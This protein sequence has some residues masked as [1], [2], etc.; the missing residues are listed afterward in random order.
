LASVQ[1]NAKGDVIER[2][3]S[4][5]RHQRGSHRESKTAWS[6]P[7]IVENSDDPHAARA[8]ARGVKNL[9]VQ[10]R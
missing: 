3:A 4:M 10:S 5:L 2:E 8:L 7:G 1:T 9:L 6:A